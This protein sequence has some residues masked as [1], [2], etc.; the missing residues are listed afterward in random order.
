MADLMNGLEKD[1]EYG[2]DRINA[3]KVDCDNRGYTINSIEADILRLNIMDAEVSNIEGKVTSLAELRKQYGAI[4]PLIVD[5]DVSKFSPY[6]VRSS[7]FKSNCSLLHIVNV[8]D[9][10]KLPEK[11]SEIT[12]ADHG[13]IRHFVAMAPARDHEGE[14]AISRAWYCERPI[15]YRVKPN[16]E[17]FDDEKLREKVVNLGLEEV[18]LRGTAD[19]FLQMGPI[20]ICFDYKRRFSSFFLE[21]EIMMQ[22][23]SYVFGLLQKLEEQ[24]D[25]R[26]D[27]AML[28]T[29]KT[30][31]NA[32]YG[33][34]SVPEFTITAIFD[35]HGAERRELDM[36]M[37]Y[38]AT[39]KK[40][41]MTGRNFM[42]EKELRMTNTGM[43][44][45][46]CD[47]LV[48]T[49]PVQPCFQLSKCNIAYGLMKKGIDITDY[50]GNGVKI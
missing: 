44:R 14:M 30:S 25:K 12:E 1:P 23:M 2:E 32:H 34:R 10:R 47:S 36:E 4:M 42:D 49:E 48:Q 37:L 8:I 28:V 5:F 35:L 15:E 21:H 43:P 22:Q 29:A 6:Q 46:S 31:R 27:K 9:A 50:F 3:F 41:M 7:E 26:F 33:E 11:V 16:P 45:F 18:V 39:I 19:C 13:H 24:G 38:L 40:E 20:A 17:L